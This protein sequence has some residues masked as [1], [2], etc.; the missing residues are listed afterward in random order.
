MFMLLAGLQTH[1]RRTKEKNNQYLELFAF[2]NIQ[3]AYLSF[4]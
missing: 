3:C 4:F 2:Y 1:F